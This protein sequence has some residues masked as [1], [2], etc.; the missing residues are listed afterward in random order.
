LDL[1]AAGR[2]CRLSTE[3]LLVVVT[4]A[5]V[6]AIGGLVVCWAA[7]SSSFTPENKKTVIYITEI[8]CKPRY[9]ARYPLRVRAWM[10]DRRGKLTR[11]TD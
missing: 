1:E 2:R 9:T 5:A 3:L 8:P 10:G 7:E 6:F 11:N 4:V